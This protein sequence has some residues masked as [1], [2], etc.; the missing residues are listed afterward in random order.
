MVLLLSNSRSHCP[1][2]YTN[3]QPMFHRQPSGTSYYE[4]YICNK[5]PTLQTRTTGLEFPISILEFATNLI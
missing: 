3:G 1:Q 2:T 5:D 4:D